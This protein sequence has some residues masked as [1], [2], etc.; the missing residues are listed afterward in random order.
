MK[1]N[2]LSLFDGDNEIRNWF[3]IDLMI[4]FCLLQIDFI[5]LFVHVQSSWNV[6]RAAETLWVDAK[7]WIIIEEIFTK[8]I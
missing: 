6:K 5:N 3:K 2:I 1:K 4:I 8:A 7:K